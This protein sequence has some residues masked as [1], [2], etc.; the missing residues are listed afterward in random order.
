[1]VV[2]EG[3]APGAGSQWPYGRRL[4]SDG[5][6]DANGLARL[7]FNSGVHHDPHHDVNHASSL[8]ENEESPEILRSSLDTVKKKRVTVQ[9]ES[10]EPGPAI[11]VNSESHRSP[12]EKGKK[13]DLQVQQD[14]K[15]KSS[16]NDEDHGAAAQ[17]DVDTVKKKRVTIQAH[18]ESRRPPPISPVIEVS[19]GSDSP[20]AERIGKKRTHHDGFDLDAR[21]SKKLKHTETPGPPITQT[22]SSY[23]TPPVII[24]DSPDNGR[25]IVQ[26]QERLQ[27]ET[28]SVD[29]LNRNATLLPPAQIHATSNEKEMQFN[30]HGDGSNTP[31]HERPQSLGRDHVASWHPGP[32]RI[33][34]PAK[35]SQQS[36]RPGPPRMG[37]TAYN[38]AERGG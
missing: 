14:V 25:P 5:H 33:E 7:S 11:E 34:S 31:R 32:S 20:P 9:V 6:T 18:V 26:A 10:Y 4:F 36:W 13:R 28:A 30:V 3:A 19:S 17:C 38:E 8:D 15:G 22:S 16:I 23:T 29:A 35:Q 1:M 27:T 37:S 12:A 21:T 2:I 24:I